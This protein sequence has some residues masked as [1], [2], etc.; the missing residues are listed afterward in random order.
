MSNILLKVLVTISVLSVLFVITAHTIHYDPVQREE[1]SRRIR[2]NSDEIRT[3]FKEF[4]NNFID[5][6]KYSKIYW[7]VKYTNTTSRRWNQYPRVEVG[8]GGFKSP[9]VNY[10]KDTLSKDLKKLLELKKK[11]ETKHSGD[12]N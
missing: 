8:P 1:E 12:L 9:I 4:L 5:T 6:L 2:V 7:N 3:N 11:M 10:P